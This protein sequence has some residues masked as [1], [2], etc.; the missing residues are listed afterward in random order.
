M[1]SGIVPENECAKVIKN[2]I[3]KPRGCGGFSITFSTSYNRSVK[4]IQ[5]YPVIAVEGPVSAI[6]T[7]QHPGTTAGTGR[8][9]GNMD[10]ARVLRTALISTTAAAISAVLPVCMPETDAMADLVLDH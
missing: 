9:A 2:S 8:C 6:G 1:C 10:G 4:V 7:G 5:R 3:K